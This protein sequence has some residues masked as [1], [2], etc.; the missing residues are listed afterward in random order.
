MRSADAKIRRSRACRCPDSEENPVSRFGPP[1]GPGFGPC[2][3][4]IPFSVVGVLIPVRRGR[5]GQP[6]LNGNGQDR[7]TRVEQFQ[8]LLGS[9]LAGRGALGL[10]GRIAAH[11]F[12]SFAKCSHNTT[13]PY[14]ATK[15]GEPQDDA[16]PPPC[17]HFRV[18][19]LHDRIKPW[20][21]QEG[22]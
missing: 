10:L 19:R 12:W 20:L 17:R 11:D 3:R 16:L 7:A 15:P 9:N 14:P 5:G 2:Y 13:G 22:R 8:A 6:K 21:L 4:G 1:T 18:R